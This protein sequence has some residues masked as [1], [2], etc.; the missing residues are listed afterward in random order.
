MSDSHH[1][2][3][4][5]ANKITSRFGGYLRSNFHI[6]DRR[7]DMRYDSLYKRRNTEQAGDLKNFRIS[8]G[9]KGNYKQFSHQG[10]AESQNDDITITNSHFAAIQFNLPQNQAGH[11]LEFDLGFDGRADKENTVGVYFNG[12]LMD[13]WKISGDVKKELFLPAKYVLDGVTWLAFK[14]VDKDAD[15]QTG[16]LGLIFRSIAQK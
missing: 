3:V 5:G 1:V 13:T 4:I 9:Q 12:V 11:T 8:F 14:R 2:N 15:G 7:G 6:P 10:F 16:D